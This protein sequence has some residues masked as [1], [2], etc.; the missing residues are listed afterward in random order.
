M[1]ASFLAAS[2][3]TITASTETDLLQPGA[4][5]EHVI[6]GIQVYNYSGSS[7]TVELLYTNSTNSLNGYYFKG[8][9]ANGDCVH[10]D[11]KQILS[12]QQKLRAKATQ[13]D[14]SFVVSYLEKT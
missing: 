11:T 1:A 3:A 12:N 8:A 13:S 7:S 4:G 5:A 9:L 2:L 10:F 14:T 6:L